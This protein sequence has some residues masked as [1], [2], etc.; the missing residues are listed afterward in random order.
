MKHRLTPA[1]AMVAIVLPAPTLASTDE[2]RTM[3]LSA[4]RR[5]SDTG[6]GHRVRDR[7]ALHLLD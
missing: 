2:A 6:S 7:R 1:F 4:R 3:W 5:S